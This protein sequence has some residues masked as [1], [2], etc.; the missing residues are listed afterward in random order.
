[1]SVAESKFDEL[2]SSLRGELHTD[3]ATRCLYATDASIYEQ[4]PLAVATPAC[5][6][7]IAALI[8][9]ANRH[10][11][12]LIPRTAG[13]SLAGQVV[14][15]GIVVDV[16]RHLTRVLEVDRRNSCVTVQPGVI[17]DDL[18]RQLARHGLFFAPETSTAN[19]AMIGGMIGNNS[20][21]A[22]S[23][24]YGDT[25]SHVR[26]LS[27]FLGD[28]TRTT[29]GVVAA[30]EFETLRKQ[31][32][33]IGTVY[34]AIHAVLCQEQHRSEIRSQFPRPTIH[35]RNTGYALDSL[36]DS[37]IFG[38]NQD[39]NLGKLLTGSE[40]TLFFTTEAKLNCVPVPDPDATLVCA[41]FNSIDEALQAN[42]IVN[43]WRPRRCELLDH[44]IIAGVRENHVREH[45][46]DF[47]NDDPQAILMI[48]LDG[49]ENNARA[50]KLIRE[51]KSKHLGSSYPVLV[52]AA[53]VAAWKSRRAAPGGLSIVA[54]HKLAVTI[55]EDAAVDIHDL[56]DFVGEV[57][58]F[59]TSDF[60]TDC[61][62]YG[63]AGAGELHLRPWLDPH[64]PDY[65]AALRAIATRFA[66]TVKK[67]GGALSGEH[68]SGR[69]RSEFIEQMVGPNCYRWMRQIKLAFDPNNIFNPGIIVDPQPMDNNLRPVPP[70]SQSLRHSTV[71]QFEVGGLAQAAAA[72]SGSGDCRKS[73][74]AGGTMCPSY[75]AT[76]N[77]SETTRARA[78][79]LRQ[80]LSGSA[81]I[82]VSDHEVRRI[83]ELCLACKACKSECPSNVD[84]AKMKAEFN[85]GYN[86]QHGVPL[87]TRMLAN[88]ERW[89]ER[90]RSLGWLGRFAAG[91]AI[92]SSM[93]KGVLGIHS[94]RQL[95]VIQRHSLRNWY[96]HRRN[97]MTTTAPNTAPNT[98][99]NTGSK[100]PVLLFCDEFTN[101]IDVDVGRATI[102]L[103]ET[104]GYQVT[105]M[106]N[107][108]SG[109]SAISLGNLSVARNLAEEN[110]R[111]LAPLVAD[112]YPMIGIE[113]SAILTLRD[114]YPDL[115]GHKFRNGARSLSQTVLTIDEFV[116][117]EIDR[118]GIVREQ[119][120]EQA[121]DVRFHGHCHQKALSS[122]A[123]TLKMLALPAGARVQEIVSGCCGMAGF[124][125]YDRDKF[126]I[127]QQIGEL[128]LF[129]A[130]RQLS[131]STVIA[132]TGT[133]CR[134]QIRDAT[135]LNALHP[136]QVLR[137]MLPTR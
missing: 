20:S 64:D 70:A 129:P 19:R 92:T 117:A 49:P 111:R 6:D 116:A 58:A 78:N 22:N 82:R 110:V 103:L 122:T 77:E 44:F 39:L 130:I 88:F 51:L 60:S 91:N 21:G 121:I 73:H 80:H 128:L 1:M 127:S 61:V 75:H 23:I 106:N 105:L 4:L 9:F 133:S 14:G 65:K 102:E 97:T 3:Q 74:L 69:C 101:Q 17:R 108:E 24:R 118:G 107:V 42:I 90:F 15:S 63:H 31:S 28:G 32:S 87:R 13:T 71:L 93:I 137:K 29:F 41:H 30:N 131:P 57:R 136:V 38:G 109:R 16:S 33:R 112:G 135:G 100:G 36:V 5:N 66:A 114:E 125:G 84:M 119:F 34:A 26:E 95:P 52:K 53:A 94:R 11:I 7:D 12:G 10:A 132:A 98:G 81:D 83:L 120:S 67:Y 40:G 37:T 134:Q 96:Q 46:F 104:I 89:C 8:H 55:I 56:P 54:K 113:P 35:R 72:C 68:G 2:K 27:G 18:N 43:Q 25:R 115:V 99:P 50:E 85:H 59:L 62:I 48:E 45:G 123:A 47:I 126:A 76:R 124:F 79:L 86:L